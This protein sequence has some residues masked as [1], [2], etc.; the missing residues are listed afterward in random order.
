[1]NDSDQQISAAAFAGS[2][3]GNHPDDSPEL[4]MTAR[5]LDRAVIGLGL[6]PFARPVRERQQIRM[7]LSTTRDPAELLRQLHDELLLLARVDPSVVETSL[8]VHP[9]VLQDFLDYN[10]FLEPAEQLL[11]ELELDGVIQIASFHPGYRFA[12][13]FPGDIENYSNRSPYPTLHL[14]R[15]ASVSA[16][17]DAYGDTDRIIE[18]NQQRLRALGLTGWR[19]LGLQVPDE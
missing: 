17:I 19:Q 8:L 10:D 5:W 13:S 16:A 6:C 7:R 12:D 3:T 2:P 1:M 11:E 14:L 4:A 9:H 18:R 15:E